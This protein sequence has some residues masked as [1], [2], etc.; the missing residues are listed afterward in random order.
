MQLAAH[1]ADQAE[2]VALLIAMFGPHQ[3]LSAVDSIREVCPQVSRRLARRLHKDLRAR[4]YGYV[5]LVGQSLKYLLQMLPSQDSSLF[6]KE[7]IC[8]HVV[9]PPLTIYA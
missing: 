1:W 2:A 6:A 9:R 7:L 3:A 5:S 8:Q 4:H